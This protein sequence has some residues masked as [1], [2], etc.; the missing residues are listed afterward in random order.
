N[1]VMR[2]ALA[3]RA[4][5]LRKVTEGIGIGE[6]TVLL[7]AFAQIRPLQVMKATGVAAVVAGENPALVVDLDPERV[8]AALGEDFVAMGFGM[9]TPDVLALRRDKIRRARAAHVCRY[10]AALGGVEPAV[11][12]PAQTVHHRV[13]VLQAEAFQMNHR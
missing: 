13:R 3:L 12:S 7:E 5:H 2:E 6:L 11:G 10:G 8:A 4:L 1:E 9:I